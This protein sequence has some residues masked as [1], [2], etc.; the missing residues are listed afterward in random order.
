ML[1][2]IRNY[3][4][5]TS[6]I[7]Q[8][9]VSG[10]P[11]EFASILSQE[12]EGEKEQHIIS[13]EAGRVEFSLPL[14]LIIH[15]SSLGFQDYTDTIYE[16][17]DHKIF[18]SP[19]YYQFDKVVVTGQ[20]RPQSLDNSIYKINI[21]DKKQIRLT[22]ANNLGDLLKNEVSFQYRPEGVLG[23]FL[24]IR[25]LTGEYV[26]IL[27]DGMPITGRVA[28]RIDLGQLSLYNVDQVEVI[29]G[30]MSVVYGSNALAGAIN[31]ITADYSEKNVLFSANAYYE[32]LGVYNFDASGSKRFGKHTASLNAARNFHGGW[33]PDEDS[34]YQI[35]KPKLQYLAGGSYQYKHKNFNLKYNTDYLYEELRDLGPL[36]LEN[37][38]EKAIDSYH[39][40]QRWNNRLNTS[41]T[42]SDD[43][44]LNMQA[45]YSYYGKRKISYI[46]DLVNLQKTIAENPDLHDTT[47]FNQVSLRGFV[48]NKSGKKFEYQTGFDLSYESAEGNRT[49]GKQYI[50]DVAG[51][52]NII[53]RPVEQ[54]SLQPGVRFIYNSKYKAPV[55]YALNIKYQPGNFT[56]RG[57]Y[58]KG[59][60]APSLKQLYLQFIDSNHEI[61]GNPDLK[62]E[63]AV[64]ISF[65]GDYRYAIGKHAIEFGADVFYNSIK[66]SIQLAIDTNRPGWGMY[67]NVEEQRYITK[68]FEAT[69]GYHFFPRLSITT[70]ILTTGRSRLDDENN[71]EYSTDFVA[72]AKYH[73]PRHK[74]ELS[75]F[76]K[77]NADYLDFAGNYTPEGELNGYGQRYIEGYNS[78]DITFSKFFFESRLTLATGIK[79]VFNVTLVEST[80]NLNIHGSGTETAAVG[81]GTTVFIKLSYRFEKY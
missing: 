79:N 3:G 62:S 67:F 64:N 69:L 45:G 19:E 39:Y 6:L 38:Y 34:R 41:N 61:Y 74:Y 54:L 65:S 81:Y 80:G 59:F 13:N 66:N 60:R 52:M 18:L 12:L 63:T 50:A 71:F 24:R 14:P 4:Q 11:V 49:K 42:F 72:T 46:N 48:S 36:E 37:L 30:P 5:K 31:I 29:E 43:F 28:G 9:K 44:I 8:D 57:N 51:F 17:G 77:Y 15:I 40:T 33:G 7:L 32:T 27:I 76:Y 58:A 78:M 70:G 1:F 35:W 16:S 22:A 68:G 56:F 2:P 47:T 10:R 23:D 26:K 20:F 25:G 21:L 55:I 73:S 53:Y 75:I